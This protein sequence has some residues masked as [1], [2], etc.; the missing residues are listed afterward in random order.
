MAYAERN[1]YKVITVNEKKL[2]SN[3]DWNCEN[4][5]THALYYHSR[6]LI[7][8]NFVL[9]GLQYVCAYFSSSGVI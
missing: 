4:K 8:D 3:I 5:Q 6:G 1:N 2:L 7:Y 9:E